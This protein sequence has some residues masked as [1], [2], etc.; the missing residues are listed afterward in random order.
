[1]QLHG[2]QHVAYK[3]MA[4]LVRNNSSTSVLLDYFSDHHPDIPLVS[5]EV[6]L[7]SSSRAVQCI[8]HAFRYLATDQDTIALAYLAQH[9]TQDILCQT[10]SCADILRQPES[11]L[12]EHFWNNGT[13]CDSSRCS[14]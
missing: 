7:L 14:S 12:P 6:F 5:D 4:I 9:Y 1:M 3:D 8:V 13:C 10:V 2:E 11:F